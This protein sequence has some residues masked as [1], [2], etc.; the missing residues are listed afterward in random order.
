MIVAYTRG[1][2][3]D[4]ERSQMAVKCKWR[5]SHQ[6]L[7]INRMQWVRGTIKDNF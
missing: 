7:V 5:Y 6:D 4:T 1:L 3:G 2:D